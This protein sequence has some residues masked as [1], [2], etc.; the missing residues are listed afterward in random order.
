M[1][2]GNR[3][4]FNG[5]HFRVQTS[6]AAASPVH[7]VTGITNAKPAVVSTAGTPFDNGSVVQ[8]T[9]IVGMTE[10]NNTQQ[11]VSTVA[12]GHFELPDIDSSG[13]NTYVSGGVMREVVFSN[14]CE[15]TGMNQQG[16]AAQQ[17]EV[18]SI[19]STA[20]EFEQ[21][22]SDT[23]T[24]QLDYNFAPL[25]GVQAALRAANL[26]GDPI[27]VQVD[28]PK[29]GGTVTAIGTVQQTS[30]QGS[31]NGVYTG[32]CTLKLTGD[33]FIQAN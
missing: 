8:F 3:Y 15:L 11:V 29:N 24:F 1:A 32:S 19:C 14:F 20:K 18:S 16:A 21:G 9:G 28:L 26:S 13:Y 27:A 7:A 12:S 22:L 25:S 23:G 5:S 33:L 4:K 6:L 31:V 17:I 2:G 30:F 10:L